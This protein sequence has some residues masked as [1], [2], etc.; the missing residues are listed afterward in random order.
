MGRRKRPAL[1]DASMLL[2]VAGHA[3]MGAAVGL[4]FCLGLMV[5]DAFQLKATIA[6]SIDPGSTRVVI[7]GTFMMAFAV[8]ASLTGLVLSILDRGERSADK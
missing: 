3:A 2:E 8:G 6:G 7:V 4:A 5:F 1:I